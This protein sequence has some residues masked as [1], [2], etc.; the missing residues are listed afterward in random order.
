MLLYQIQLLYNSKGFQQQ[1]GLSFHKTVG[2]TSQVQVSELAVT[3]LIAMFPEQCFHLTVMQAGRLHESSS[4]ALETGTMQHCCIPI[5]GSFIWWTLLA[6]SLN[7]Y[8]WEFSGGLKKKIVG[9]AAHSFFFFL[10][11][12]QRAHSQGQHDSINHCNIR[13]EMMLIVQ[14]ILTR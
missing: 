1:A 8:L 10:R 2:K 13:T 3:M 4:F 9:A 11:E 7:K 12:T 6:G 14:K 5:T